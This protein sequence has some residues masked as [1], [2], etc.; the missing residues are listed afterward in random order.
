MKKIEPSLIKGLMRI[1]GKDLVNSVL[2][3]SHY[4][5]S[6]TLGD[7]ESSWSTLRGCD[8]L[9][10]LDQE[11]KGRVGKCKKALGSTTTLELL[12][13]TKLHVCSLH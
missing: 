10:F 3:L 12:V 1:S 9:G 8:I 13:G 6:H 2:E 7:L 11:G 4:S 5:L